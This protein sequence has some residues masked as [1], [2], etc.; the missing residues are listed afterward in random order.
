[1]ATTVYFTETKDFKLIKE[2]VLTQ[3]DYYLVYVYADTSNARIPKEL[4]RKLPYYGNN[5]IWIDTARMDAVSI[6]NHMVLTIGQLMDPEEEIDFLIVS[7]TS[8]YD[9]LVIFLRDQGISVDLVKPE[10]VA[11]KKTGTGKKRGRP[12][13]AKAGKK[14]RPKKTTTEA[15]GEVK[16]EKKRR[17]R[18]PKSESEKAAVK[19]TKTQ[20]GAKVKKTRKPRVEKEITP[21]EVDA[22]ITALGT[23]DYNVEKVAR[24]LFSVSKIKRPKLKINL[25]DLIKRETA[26]DDLGAE[27]L[28]KKL[29]ELKLVEINEKS[30]RLNYKD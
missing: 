18:P 25:L 23:L 9:K 13:K 11:T 15:A 4:I 20:K 27:E 29:N 10:G 1:M 8:R 30:G 6:A 5:L 26:E 28:F 17:G 16:P 3:D 21:E 22:K 19:K 2:R 24:K 14:G 12:K 7:K